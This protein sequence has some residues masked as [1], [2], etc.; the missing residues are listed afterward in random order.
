M[1]SRELGTG[2]VAVVVQVGCQGGLFVRSGSSGGHVRVS[3]VQTS[4]EPLP[5]YC[6]FTRGIY[7]TDIAMKNR[8]I[9]VNDCETVSRIVH[10]L[11]LVSEGI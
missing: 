5:Q 4:V 1:C 10:V 6:Q 2:T 7:H 11:R 8:Y 3:M 9:G